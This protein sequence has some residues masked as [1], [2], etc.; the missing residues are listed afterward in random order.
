[1]QLVQP[2]VVPDDTHS[3]WSV[4][5]CNHGDE[6]EIQSNNATK[7]DIISFERSSKKEEISDIHDESIEMVS[8][9]DS[10]QGSSKHIQPNAHM[11]NNIHLHSRPEILDKKSKRRSSV[12]DE[13]YREKRL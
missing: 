1:M 3:E 12:H 10:D 6:K 8:F 11:I 5:I 13:L 4:D 2:E 7:Q 9:K